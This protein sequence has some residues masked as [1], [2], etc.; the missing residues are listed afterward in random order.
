M[1]KILIAGVLMILALASCT[2]YVYLPFPGGINNGGGSGSEEAPSNSEI[3]KELA[4][5]NIVDMM[6]GR[7]QTPAT[8]Q[9][10]DTSTA[11]ATGSISLYELNSPISKT[12]TLTEHPVS[13]YE[14]SG[15]MTVAF[16]GNGIYVTG[17]TA[18]IDIT[19]AGDDVLIISGT[20]VQGVVT[21]T[22]SGT[23]FTDPTPAAF[24]FNSTI[25]VNGETVSPNGTEGNGTENTP[26]ELS[27][28][29]ELIAFAN[30]VNSGELN[31]EGRYYALSA[32]V[33]LGGMEWTPIGI[34]TRSGSDLTDE[35]NPFKGTFNGNNHSVTDFTMT[36]N[37]ED[38]GLGFFSALDGARVE[39][40]RLQGNIDATANG[41]AGMVAGL[42]VNNSI[43]SNCTVIEGSTI[44]AK[45]A[46]GIVG[47]MVAS[48]II[49][50]C[51]NNASITTTGKIGGIANS[52][53][54]DQH[55][56]ETEE[57]IYE[58]FQII[59]C[60]N[61]GN[62]TGGTGNAGG[63]VG[64]TGPVDII[65]CYNYGNITV[66]NAPAVGGI[67]GDMRAGATMTGCINEGNITAEGRTSGTYGIGGLAG[68]IRYADD[69]GNTYNLYR[70]AT[71]SGS[72]NRGYVETDGGTG[73]GGAVGMIYNAAAISDSSNTGT[74]KLTGTTGQDK[75][76]GGFIGGMQHESIS[77]T[78]STVRRTISVSNCS[79]AEDVVS[80]PDGTTSEGSFVGHPNASTSDCPITVTFIDCTPNG[81]GSGIPTAE[82]S[83]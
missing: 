18:T 17:F 64:L 31:T 76:I 58:P 38:E 65:S 20:D 5:V 80:A 77:Y 48:G 9:I 68:W 36:S 12:A 8:V 78:A 57:Q 83:V 11:S 41:S 81:D 28:A 30:A 39:N 2:Q 82:G 29:A 42:S 40:L 70:I 25:T 26:Y 55:P 44:N 3:V 71:I 75:M 61:H 6:T 74:V 66:G 34:S 24:S 51:I 59:G 1:K 27:T 60:E 15:T 63:I 22:V 35:S 21:A 53:Y 62:L 67:V 4:L 37:E 54:Y 19:A 32:D 16:T 14:L 47:R 56:G 43:I 50:N 33:N 52:A 13:G 69:T 46:G 23:G 7:K 73:I 79:S 49:E 45:E 72:H 10:T